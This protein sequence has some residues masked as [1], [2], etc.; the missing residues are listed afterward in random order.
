MLQKFWGM[1]SLF[2]GRGTPERPG[3]GYWRFPLLQDP[4]AEHP[5]SLHSAGPLLKGRERESLRTG[6]TYMIF[7]AVPF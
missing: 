7:A 1:R 2:F 5:P 6:G 3:E 4:A